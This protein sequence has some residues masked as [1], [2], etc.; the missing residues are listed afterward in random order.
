MTAPCRSGTIHL[1]DASLSIWE[2]PKV[3]L[4]GRNAWETQFKRD[5][6]AR[7]IQ[8]LNRIGWTCTMPEVDAASVKCYGGNVARWSAQRRRFC[9]KGDLKADLEISGRTISLKMFQSVNCPTRPDHEGRYESNKEAVMP[10]VLR[11]EMQR[12]RRRICDYLCAVLGGYEVAPAK[13]ASPS[14]DPLAFFNSSWTDHR[15][16]RDRAGWPSDRALSSWSRTDQDGVPLHHGDVRFIRDAR[17]GRL[18]RGRVYG[19]INGMWT[20]VYG[21]GRRDH[22]CHPA[23]QFFSYTPGLPRKQVPAKTRRKQLQRELDK[24]VSS[25]QFERAAVLRDLIHPDRT[26]PR[27]AAKPQQRAAQEHQP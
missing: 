26:P 17:N 16:E 3:P 1:G 6:F 7:I 21:P 23:N 14:P 4:I 24:A 27:N 25:M 18:R 15:F 12:T 9:V 19:G 11:L 22:E 10:Y 13:V 8:T 20:F 5:V 2:E